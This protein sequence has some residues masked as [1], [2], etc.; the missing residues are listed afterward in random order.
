MIR[1]PVPR[2]EKTWEATPPE[3]V[4]TRLMDFHSIHV[5][6]LAPTDAPSRM[7][8]AKAEKMRRPT[9]TSGINSE[10]YNYFLQRLTQYKT[11]ALLSGTDIIFQLLEC[12]DEDLRKDHERTSRSETSVLEFI[13]HLAVKKKKHNGCQA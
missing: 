3:S 5:H 11:A 10:D 7:P 9:L 4:L 2:C 1:C 12:C 13:H 6:P 8:A